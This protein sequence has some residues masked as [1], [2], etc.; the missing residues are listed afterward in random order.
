M[1][2]LNLSDWERQVIAEVEA[3][4]LWNDPVTTRIVSRSFVSRSKGRG[5]YRRHWK[6]ITLI[7]DRANPIFR[8]TLAH[9]FQFDVIASEI[10]PNLTGLDAEAKLMASCAAQ[11]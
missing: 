4:V 1:D 8:F 9:R 5:R 2:T 11:F 6:E 3:E 10:F 7:H